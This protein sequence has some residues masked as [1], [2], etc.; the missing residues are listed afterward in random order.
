MVKRPRCGDGAAMASAV[1][2]MAAVYIAYTRARPIHWSIRLEASGCNTGNCDESCTPP[3]Q[4]YLTHKQSTPHS[5]GTADRYKVRT[6]NADKLVKYLRKMLP[7]FI[8]K[9]WTLY[10][11]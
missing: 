9:L 3:G 10:A 6:E 1:E 4:T 8:E 5:R 2:V 7:F 11:S